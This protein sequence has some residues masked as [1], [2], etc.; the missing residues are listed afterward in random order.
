MSLPQT[1]R[2]RLRISLRVSMVAVVVLAVAMA[3]QVNKARE[4]REAVAAVKKFGGW[5]HYDYEFVNGPVK[6]PQGNDIWMPP[7][8]KLTPGRSPRAPIW[9]RRM[10]GDEYFREIAHV[11]LFVD[12]EKGQAHAGPWNIGPAADVLAQLVG[13]SGIKTLQIGGQQATDRGMEYVGRMEGLEELIIW[14]AREISDAGVS[15]LEGLKHL[16]NVYIDKSRMTDE[17]LRTLGALPGVEH[18]KL[19]NH[20]FSDAGLAHLKK[21]SRL[22]TLM[23]GSGRSDITDAGLASLAGMKDLEQLDI[24]GSK[25]TAR[26]L[27]QL[28]VL[29]RLKEIRIGNEDGRLSPADIERLKG[30]CPA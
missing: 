22:K 14:P 15:H 18:L 4:Q 23:V 12:I 25:V 29:P 7:W 17:G 5:V 20:H 24:S 2:R 10:L 16:K 26:G 3:R 6:V 8:G 21:A 27:L 30:R 19:S 13:Q 9:L 1:L 28:R 11:S